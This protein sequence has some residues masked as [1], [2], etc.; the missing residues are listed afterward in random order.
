M[1]IF[2]EAN[3]K[4]FKDAIR[5][6]DHKKI[7]ETIVYQVFVRMLERKNDFIITIGGDDTIYYR[8]RIMD[9]TGIENVITYDEAT[10]VVCGYDIYGSR[11]APFGSTFNGR[12]NIAGMSFMYMALDP[13]VAC[14][15]VYP[16]NECLISLA[17]F[18]IINKLNVVDLSKDASIIPL[19]DDKDHPIVVN[20]SEILTA[21]ME[22]FCLPVSDGDY[23]VTQY[24]SNLIRNY[25]FDGIIYKGFA[26]RGTNC[27]IFNC[28]SRNFKFMSSR[29]LY[30]PHPLLGI[31]DVSTGQEL[32]RP[33]V[34]IKSRMEQ[35]IEY[36][37]CREKQNKI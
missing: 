22:T 7:E 34:P 21:C 24:L 9:K 37:R 25:G 2:S 32:P 35:I 6:K 31:Y 10:N 12:N 29:V 5:S 28:A 20:V 15:E 4:E 16:R 1:N 8:A 14:A 23:Y 18:K 19:K 27:T 36:A 33:Q 30:T 26:T 17:E 11:E 3:Y 13:F